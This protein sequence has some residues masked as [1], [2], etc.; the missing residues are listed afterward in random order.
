VSG[1]P[2]T[3]GNL[4]AARQA[5]L[6][7][8]DWG[9]EQAAAQQMFATIGAD[10]AAPRHYGG[11]PARGRL[12]PAAFTESGGNAPLAIRSRTISRAADRAR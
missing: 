11:G 5:L 6:G 9:S 12:L 8:P 1:N 2:C 7:N 10:A 4:S 3:Y